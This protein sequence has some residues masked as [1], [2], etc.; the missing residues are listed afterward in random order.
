MSR[1]VDATY[2]NILNTIS[3][4]MDNIVEAHK[5]AKE[6]MEAAEDAGHVLKQTAE[7]IKLRRKER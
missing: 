4:A 1:E 5:R 6:A 3:N 2:L 7:L